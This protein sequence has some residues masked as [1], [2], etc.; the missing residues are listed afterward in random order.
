MS[1]ISAAWLSSSFWEGVE[2]VSEAVVTIGALFEGLA[3]FGHIFKN[4]EGRRK[5]AE[6]AAFAALVVGL[7]TGLM[8][9]MRTN[10]LSS[11][12]ISGL[13]TEARDARRMADDSNARAEKAF[14][15]AVVAQQRADKANS[16]LEI[17]RQKTAR[18]QIEAAKAEE[19][20]L[21][22]LAQQGAL[23]VR[24]L[25]LSTY[26]DGTTN[27]D[28]LRKF[29]GTEA[30]IEYD[31]GYEPRIA[32][33]CVEAVLTKA[34]WKILSNK[35][36]PQVVPHALP[37]GGF[38]VMPGIS[39]DVSPP[40]GVPRSS[41]GT[42]PID[43]ME[44]IKLNRAED[45]FLDFAAGSGWQKGSA[46]PGRAGWHFI[47][48]SVGLDSYRLRN[49]FSSPTTARAPVPVRGATAPAPKKIA[50]SVSCMNLPKP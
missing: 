34:G 39:A 46:M 5:R 19:D 13:Y 48:I 44:N 45:T 24:E 23:V 21:T 8:A 16:D 18:F 50:S 28:D 36:A 3:D 30:Y 38:Q 47:K 42:E 40:L 27:I 6:K 11:D 9:L 33:S 20:L 1:W 43:M 49:F 15:R 10:K 32:A 14:D 22:S 2:Y 26:E 4:D 31:Q 37:T 35:Q 25:F 17:E 29:A 41:P 12:T 7:A